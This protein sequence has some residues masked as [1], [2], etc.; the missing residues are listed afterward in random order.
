MSA[1][2]AV[3]CCLESSL[4]SCGPAAKSRTLGLRLTPCPLGL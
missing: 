1:R 4:A 3:L 2:V